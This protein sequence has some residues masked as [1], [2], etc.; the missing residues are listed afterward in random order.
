MQSRLSLETSNLSEIV[1]P[2][3][4]PSQIVE[5]RHRLSRLRKSYLKIPSDLHRALLADIFWDIVGDLRPRGVETTTYCIVDM[6]QI[7]EIMFMS[8]VDFRVDVQPDLESRWYGGEPVSVGQACRVWSTVHR[9]MF[10]DD[11]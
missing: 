3:D 10:P 5:L 6:G 11:D 1:D 4:E 2:G 8:S 9:E 7:P